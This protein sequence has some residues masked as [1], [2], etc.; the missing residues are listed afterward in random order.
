MLPL[1]TGGLGLREAAYVAVLSAWGVERAPALALGVTA[2]AAQLIVAL[3]G[4]V[5]LWTMRG[6]L[7]PAAA[8]GGKP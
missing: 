4:G 6:A 5:V 3:A 1:S 8:E 2:L 7:R